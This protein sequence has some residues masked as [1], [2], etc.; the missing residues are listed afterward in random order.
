[1]FL[2]SSLSLRFRIRERE[3]ILLYVL[4]IDP[5]SFASL[6]VSVVVVVTILQVNKYASYNF[7]VMSQ[8]VL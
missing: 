7:I 2:E 8:D 3:A 4:G 1:M 6:Q 5:A